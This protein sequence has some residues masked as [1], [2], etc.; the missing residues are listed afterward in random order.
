[1]LA[2]AHTEH[3]KPKH[4]GAVA[5]AG[6]F[7][8]ELVDTAGTLTLHITQHGEPLATQ[9]GKAVVTAQGAAKTISFQLAPSGE[10]RFTAQ[11]TLSNSGAKSVTAVI[12]MP[13]LP[14][15]TLQFDLK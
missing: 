4:G 7:Q 13:G 3:G 6:L 12:T 1:M 2:T 8:A 5:E 15:R 14:E 10:N 11:G 9:G